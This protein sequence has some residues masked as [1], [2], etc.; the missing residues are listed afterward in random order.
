MILR[1][2]R[3]ISFSSN[4]FCKYASAFNAR[5]F[6]LVFLLFILL[7]LGLFL[8]WQQG[9]VGIRS[10]L[11]T[12]RLVCVA[13]LVAALLTWVAASK[14]GSGPHHFLPFFAAPFLRSLSFPKAQNTHNFPN[15]K[16]SNTDD[17]DSS[18]NIPC[19][20]QSHRNASWTGQQW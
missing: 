9:S 20:R 14:T 5:P 11:G 17:H 3:K 16:R 6:N 12:H 2:Q 15:E 18:R 7:P 19:Q 10:W 13:A 8:L 4:G 1:K